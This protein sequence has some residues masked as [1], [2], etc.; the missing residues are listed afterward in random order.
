MTASPPGPDRSVADLHTNVQLPPGAALGNQ[1][2]GPIVSDAPTLP[3][4]LLRLARAC[5]IAPEWNDAYGQIQHVPAATL[6]A[7]LAALGFEA[8]SPARIAESEDRLHAFG[9]PAHAPLV[10]ARVGEAVVWRG[11]PEGAG[12][13]DLMLEDGRHYGCTIEALPG[14]WLRIP[15]IGMAGYHRLEHAGVGTVVAVAPQRAWTIDDACAAAPGQRWWGLATQ[16]YSLRA[17]ARAELAGVGGYAALACVAENAGR[18]GAQALAVSPVHAL[19]SADPSR[20]SPYSPSSRRWLNVLHADASP[21]FGRE[22]VRDAKRRAGVAELAARLEAQTLIDWPGVAQV[23]F[24]YLRLLFED[25]FAFVDGRPQARNLMDDTLAENFASFIDEGGVA[26]VRHACFEALHEH[27]RRE[28]GTPGGGFHD[29]PA[30]FRDPATP[31]VAAFAREHQHEIGFHLYLQWLAARGLSGAQAA[32]R[33]AGMGIGLIGDL[34]VGMDHGGS[35]AWCSQGQVLAGL[36]VGAPPDLLNPLGQSWGLATYS[37]AALAASGYRAFIDMLR[38]VMRSAG[39][40]RID[41]V[42]GLRRL[43]LAPPGGGGAYLQM[44]FEDLLRLVVLES[45]RNRAVVIGEDLGTVPDGLRAALADHGISGMRVLWF[46][47]DSVADG[48]GFSAPERWPRA[49]VALTTT[50]DL[51]TVAGWWAGRDI[52][53]REKLGIGSAAD[54][55]RQRAERAIDRTLMTEP[56]VVDT[57]GAAVPPADVAFD[58]VGRS[59]CALALVQAEDLLGLVEQPNIPGTRDEHPNWR[60]RLPVGCGSLLDT[61]DAAARVTVL[62]AARSRP[63]TVPLVGAWH[64]SATQPGLAAVMRAVRESK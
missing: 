1:A 33:G 45:W 44:P 4:D 15:A 16:I 7:L 32:A 13:A 2:A 51:P 43:W 3:P 17:D 35:E 10:T 60:R 24:A 22:R 27:F 19:F 12:A 61:P 48:S 25:A 14:G 5:G 38:A 63:L 11:R 64:P 56:P 37:P 31:E 21:A 49:S 9:H 53:W 18:Q 62:T 6:R 39:G 29:W 59:A 26:L 55:E 52:D 54:I 42:L 50:H 58:R 47:R 46:E 40:I 8:D 34:A 23:R 20:Y 36:S 28:H 57:T 41:H 30:A